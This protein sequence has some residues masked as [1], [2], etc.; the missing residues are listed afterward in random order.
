VPR[1]RL[2]SLVWLGS[3]LAGIGLGAYVLASWPEPTFQ[4]IRLPYGESMPKTPRAVSEPQAPANRVVAAVS[5]VVAPRPQLAVDKGQKREKRELAGPPPVTS[6]SERDGY[7]PET[8]EEL[9]AKALPGMY[10]EGSEVA[11]TR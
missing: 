5:S 11:L 6:S 7:R 2:G 4:V 8:P 10:P 9:G 3:I 1:L